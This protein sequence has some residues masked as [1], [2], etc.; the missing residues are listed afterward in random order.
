MQLDLD[1][2]GMPSGLYLLSIRTKDGVL[3]RRF[4]KD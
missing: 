2:L 4:V 1:K 3:S